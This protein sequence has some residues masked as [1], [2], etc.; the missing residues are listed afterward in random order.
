MNYRGGFVSGF[1]A[2]V[3]IIG[4]TGAGWWLLAAKP[5]AGGKQGAAIP[6]AV[7]KTFKEDQSVG[8]TLTPEAEQR[9]GVRTAPVERKSVARVRMYGGEVTIPPGRAV[10][11]TAP[12]A[13]VLQRSGAVPVA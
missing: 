8:V 9:L 1:I 12:L 4:A 2:A 11:V 10:A 7:A 13:G 5:A 3:L 6:A